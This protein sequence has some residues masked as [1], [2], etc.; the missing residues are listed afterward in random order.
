MTCAIP[1]TVSTV[2]EIDELWIGS[3]LLTFDNLAWQANRLD[4]NRLLWT[5]ATKDVDDEI[6]TELLIEISRG[7]PLTVLFDAEKAAA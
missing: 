7:F 3:V 4:K 1:R 6:T 2:E 5:A